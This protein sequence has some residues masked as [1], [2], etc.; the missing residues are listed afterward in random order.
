MIRLLFLC[1]MMA[2]CAAPRKHFTAPTR[3]PS[4]T[5]ISRDIK[6]SK[7]SVGRAY[8]SSLRIEDY[9]S[10]IEYKADRLLE[11]WGL[12]DSRDPGYGGDSRKK[13]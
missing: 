6:D 8:K 9:R 10:R 11:R 4:L 7:A 5:P 1:L 2:G 13:P 3:A 12:R